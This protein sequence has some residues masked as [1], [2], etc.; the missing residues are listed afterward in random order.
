M[1]VRN[2]VKCADRFGLQAGL[3][4]WIQDRQSVELAENV[5]ASHQGLCRKRGKG[6]GR[7]RG[8][9]GGGERRLHLIQV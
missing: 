5:S 1:E 4:V 2:G 7:G 9:E 3:T 6:R 8:R